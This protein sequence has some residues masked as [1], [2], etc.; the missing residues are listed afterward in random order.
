MLCIEA[1]AEKKA[2]IA[3][4]IA[5][6]VAGGRFGMGPDKLE[7]G[8]LSE[9]LE[10]TILDPGANHLVRNRGDFFSTVA[11]ARLSEFVAA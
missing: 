2:A 7:Y 5:A 4:P 6:Q 10:D 3:A 1:N 9:V 8:R 11:L